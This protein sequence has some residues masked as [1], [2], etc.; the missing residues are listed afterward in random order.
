M[1]VVY[2]PIKWIVSKLAIVFTFVIIMIIIFTIDPLKPI[3]IELE[4]A[5]LIS[6]I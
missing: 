1:M 2:T 6:N 4:I 5:H 3:G